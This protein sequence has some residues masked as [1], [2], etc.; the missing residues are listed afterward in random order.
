MG[1]G[2]GSWGGPYSDGNTALGGQTFTGLNTPN[3]Q[4]P[5]SMSR[6]TVTPNSAWSQLFVENSIP[7]PCL[8]PCGER[9]PAGGGRGLDPD[10]L[11]R[12]TEGQ[13]YSQHFAARSHHPGGV[14]AARC[15]GSVTFYSENI[16]TFVWNALSSA[17][18]NDI[19]G[20]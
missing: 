16:D 4:T 20:E 7:V 13:T 14:N 8:T 17:Y 2:A 1:G 3:N 15:D 11:A 10:S 5:D 19:A 12:I 6:V 18:G 9:P